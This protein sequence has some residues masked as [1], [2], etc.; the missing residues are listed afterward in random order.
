ML[1]SGREVSSS[2][3]QIGKHIEAEVLAA[4]LFEKLVRDNV[5]AIGTIGTII[6]AESLTLLVQ[7]W[8]QGMPL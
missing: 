1:F 3:T 5:E 8:P 2:S 7:F 4:D 6:A